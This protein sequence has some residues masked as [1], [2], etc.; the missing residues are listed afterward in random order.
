MLGLWSGPSYF[1]GWVKEA[2]KVPSPFLR[3][4]F[5]VRLRV[6]FPDDSIVKNLPAMQETYR[7][8]RFNP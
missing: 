8:C 4:N 1:P 6:G 3:F 2:P 5:G 7:R